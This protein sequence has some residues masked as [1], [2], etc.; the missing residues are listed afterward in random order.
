MG[1]ARDES[2]SANEK[3]ALDL[4]IETLRNKDHDISTKPVSA[5]L[6]KPISPIIDTRTLSSK[7]TWLKEILNIVMEGLAKNKDKYGKRYCPCRI[8]TGNEEGDKKIIC[9]CIYHKG[10]IEN[11]GMCH[12]ML[13]FK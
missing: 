4:V 11:D 2:I 10:E 13:F 12:C 3:F 1:G 7:N 8:V 6:T 5:I 9:P